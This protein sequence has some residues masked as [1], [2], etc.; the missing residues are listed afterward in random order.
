[1]HC[2]CLC[3]NRSSARIRSSSIRR[4][5]RNQPAAG[6]CVAGGT[7]KCD[8]QSCR[9]RRVEAERQV[10]R[11]KIGEKNSIITRKLVW[12]AFARVQGSGRKRRCVCS[13][14]SKV[15]STTC[16]NNVIVSLS[17]SLS[18][19]LHLCTSRAHHEHAATCVV[20]QAHTHSE[21]LYVCTGQ[22]RHTHIL[23]AIR[24]V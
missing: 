19:V 12:C 4:R 21:S 2:R 22:G 10:A 17:L 14:T 3:L 13:R 24:C 5:A 8:D 16:K 20:S 11:T 1:M 15:I 23:I 18:C 6:L 9:R 7:Q